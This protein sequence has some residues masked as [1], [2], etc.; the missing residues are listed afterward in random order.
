MHAARMCPIITGMLGTVWLTGAASPASAEYYY[1]PSA[2]CN[3]GYP[4]HAYY[5]PVY[6]E[7]DVYVAP[8]SY[9]Y[10]PP[11]RRTVVYHTRPYYPTRYYAAPRYYYPSHRHYVGPVRSYGVRAHYYRPGHSY[12]SY[13]HAAPYYYG[14]R[15]SIGFSFG[16]THYGRHS[17]RHY[18]GGFSVTFGR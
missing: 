11:V 16:R 5:A 3:P 4:V 18:G 9:Y 6:Y 12:R 1:Y 14:G 7:R 13:R 15:S 17:S 8:R 10:A 2:Y